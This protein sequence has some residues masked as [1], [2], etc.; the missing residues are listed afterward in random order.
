MA[1]LSLEE[2]Q[3]AQAEVEGFQ[4]GPHPA[5]NNANLYTQ[6]KA[7]NPQVTPPIPTPVPY[8]PS[9]ETPNL[10]LSTEDMSSQAANNFV[11]IDAVFPAGIGP[12]ATVPVISARLQ[13]AGT[14]APQ[15]VSLFVPTTQL[16]AVSLFM[17]C[18]A[19]A[20][21]AGHTVVCTITGF[22]PLGAETITIDLLL[23]QSSNQIVMETYPL[24]VEGGTTLTLSTAYAGGAT[25]DPYTISARLVQMP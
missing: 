2:L 12:G 6:E 8:Y 13:A 5:L 14:T 15:S 10:N 4:N 19:N 24:L 18:S 21:A 9:S 3:K 7:G 22:S 1:T 11:I 17:Q 23:D 16:I 20:G 25:N